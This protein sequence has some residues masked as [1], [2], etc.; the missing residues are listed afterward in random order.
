MRLLAPVSVRSLALASLGAAAATGYCVMSC[1]GV[2]PPCSAKAAY[3]PEYVLVEYQA[4]TEMSTPKLEARGTPTYQQGHPSWDIVAVRMPDTCRDDTAVKATG[5]SRQS[6]TIFTTRCGVYMAEVERALVGAGYRVVSW[7]AL[8]LMEAQQHLSTYV[9]AKQLGA[10]IVF[11]FNSLEASDI[12]SGNVGGA[13]IRYFGSNIEGEKGEPRK[14]EDLDRKAL[15]A[16]VADRLGAVETAKS[17]VA[18]AA[19]LDTTAVLSDTGEAVWF[20]RNSETE[21]L[22]ST[23]GNRFLFVK[24][25]EQPYWYPLRPRSYVEPE[26]RREEAASEELVQG[27]SRA[28]PQDK[29]A[30]KRLDLMRKVAKDFVSRFHGP[31]PLVPVAAPPPPSRCTAAARC[32]AAGCGR[33]A[34]LRHAA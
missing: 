9:A 12:L 7:N 34:A 29:Y 13:S 28:A 11:M 15:K 17:L 2:P 16:F 18:L 4:G 10:K 20:Y 23:V 22:R 21:L 32:S 31:E 26:M 8:N 33:R 5:Q 1:T 19:T 30:A 6:E 3:Q 14:V 27:E 24:P 25:P